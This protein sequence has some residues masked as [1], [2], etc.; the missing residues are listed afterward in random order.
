MDILERVRRT[1]RRYELAGP[2]TRVVVAL[3]GGP[4]S[5]ALT[6][7]LERLDAEGDLRLAG[8]AHFNHQLRASADADERFCSELAA[9]IGRPFFADREDVAARAKGERRSLEDAA[10]TA[11][12]A[13]FE[14]ARVHF[15]ADVVA[16]GHTKDDQAETF[17]LRL[18]RGA[19]VRGLAS[20]HPRR[21]AVVRPLLACRRTDVLAF[22]TEAH[23]SWVHD[24]TNDDV[25]IPRNRVRAELLPFLVRFNPSIVDIL[26]D[27]AEMARETAQWLSREAAELAARIG[28]QDEN[29][30]YRLEA[31]GLRHAP[32]ALAREVIHQA[33]TRAA[34]GRTVSFAHVDA[35]LQLVGDA[36]GGTVDAPGQRVE[37][38][39][40]D[41]V[42]WSRPA[43]QI[44]RWTPARPA[45]TSAFC[46]RLPVP[47]Q[48]ELPEAGL[49]VSATEASSMQSVDA[50]PRSGP[51]AIVRR[52]SVAGGL[53]V[54][55]RRL[56][57]RFRPMG[58]GGAKKLQDFLVDRKVP[59][60]LRDTVPLVVDEHD[61]IVWVAGHAVDEEFGVT[62]PTEAVVI[63]RLKMLGGPR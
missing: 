11:R 12:H 34:G 17:L 26:A 36:G 23:A 14:R 25:S 22:L 35:V 42:L 43:G 46:Y 51:V 1:I 52:Q 18:L 32:V 4:D 21:G 49:V 13:F 47:G 24:E 61:R 38:D 54:R 6:Y 56:G 44:G 2:D 31:D 45:P 20:M 5:V 55:N 16:L 50:V 29:G 39:G 9:T 62:N 7:I 10:R 53:S 63:L 28:R 19:G 27:E 48:V 40:P 41:V 59:R 37:R 57:D 33:M 30:V 58:L 8:V 15:Q 60:H 3:S